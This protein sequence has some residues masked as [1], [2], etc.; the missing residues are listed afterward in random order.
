MTLAETHRASPGAPDQF[1]RSLGQVLVC[2]D[3]GRN[4]A[5]HSDEA[6]EWPAVED[7][8]DFGTV[9]VDCYRTRYGDDE[10]DESE[11]RTREEQQDD[12]EP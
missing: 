12:R 2:A 8:N 1:G 9:C 7:G 11:R 3:C 10:A 6:R 5:W 4:V